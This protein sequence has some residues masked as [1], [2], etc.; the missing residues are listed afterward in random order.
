MKTRIYFFTWTLYLCHAGIC[1]R[2]FCS[3]DGYSFFYDSMST[4]E[5][6]CVCAM[7]NVSRSGET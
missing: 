3:K 6:V 5:I 4:S 2:M 1:E 7:V